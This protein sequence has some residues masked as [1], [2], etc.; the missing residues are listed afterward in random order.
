[1]LTKNLFLGLTALTGLVTGN[2]LYKRQRQFKFN[3]DEK[4]RGVNLGGWLLLEPWITPSFFDSEPDWVVDEYTLAQNLGRDEYLRRLT[5]H[6][7]NFIRPEDL[8][9]IRD[10]GMNHIRV[11]I[12]YWSIIPRQGDP[13]VDGAYPYL[14]RILDWAE[15]RRL[16]VMVDL[17]GAHGSQNGFDNSG[18]R[19]DVRFGQGTSVDETRAVLQK[20]RDDLANHPAVS[21]IQVVNEP[22][23]AI[24]G[25]DKVEQLYRDTWGDFRDSPVVTAF[26]DAFLGVNAWN[27]FGAGMDGL[28]LDTHHYEI[29][30]N[31]QLRLSPEG[32]NQ[33]ACGF[34]DQM[35]QN[36][37]WT[38]SG[39]WTGAL[40]DCTKHLNGRGL[41]ARYDGTFTR[42]SE[43]SSYIGSCDGKREGTVAALSDADKSNI[44]GFINAQLDAYEKRTGWIF[45]T[46]KTE[47]SPEWDMQALLRNGIFPSPVTTR[48]AAGC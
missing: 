47:S 40:T 28:L 13:Y 14:G 18:Q 46:W 41:G 6:W 22:Q 19:G 35:A 43:T 29:F 17:H 44:R 12:G 5:P 33:A 8:D 21:S 45:W 26:H 24:I 1:M 7:E 38:I 16:K 9:E 34:G 4:V 25:S 3:F 27:G 2:P 32:H 42:G 31:D 10:A 36:N 11:P 20:L 48:N 37:L 30:N 39:E 23:G 15:D